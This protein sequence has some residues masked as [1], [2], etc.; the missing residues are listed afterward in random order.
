MSATTIKAFDT[1]LQLT[2]AWL[3]ELAEQM[4]NA[5]PTSRLP[6]AVGSA[7]CPPR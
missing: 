4:G 2:Y 5:R 3:H 6:R 1:T 7:A